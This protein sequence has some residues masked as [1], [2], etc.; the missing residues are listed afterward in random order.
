MSEC[1]V[2][3]KDLSMSYGR[4]DALKGVSFQL[5]AGT[6]VALTGA[7]GSGKSTLLKILAGFI[8]TYRG[9]ASILGQRDTWLTKSEVCFHPSYPWFKPGQRVSDAVKMYA[10]LRP[11]YRVAEADELFGRFGFDMSARLGTLSKGRLALALFILSMGVNARVYLL[12]EPFGGIDI[13]TRDEMRE[14][15]LRQADERRLF[16]IATHEL[17][18][19]ERLFDRFILL[20]HGRIALD[21]Q[22]DDL[23]E[24]YG[25]SI[26]ELMRRKL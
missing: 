19:M 21:G 23:R 3:V 12:D 6:L 8:Q 17:S 14:V 2:S 1:C 7:N 10:A 18:D 26:A 25:C 15:L 13:K 22:S 24:Q 16:L 9:E 4:G 11:G 20:D 5:E